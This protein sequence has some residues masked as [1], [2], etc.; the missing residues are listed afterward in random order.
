MYKL[1]CPIDFHVSKLIP[2]KW[3]CTIYFIQYT[4][5]GNRYLYGEF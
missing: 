2:Q 1:P 5:D 3:S 4:H